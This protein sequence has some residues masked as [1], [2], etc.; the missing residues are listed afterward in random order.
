MNIFGGF[1]GGFFCLGFLGFLGFGRRGQMKFCYLVGVFLRYK[2][3]IPIF[4]V[5]DTHE[6]FLTFS[7]ELLRLPN[8]SL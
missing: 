8:S 4:S 3:F 6:V 7:L 1:L 5:Y 2:L